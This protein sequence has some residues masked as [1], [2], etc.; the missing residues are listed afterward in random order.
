M[1]GQ[2]GATRQEGRQCVPGWNAHGKGRPHRARGVALAGVLT[3]AVA[4]AG[5][6]PADA[7][8]NLVRGKAWGANGSVKTIDPPGISVGIGRVALQQMPCRP[9]LGRAYLNQIDLSEFGGNANTLDLGT[10]VN[11]GIV[12]AP[13][14]GTRRLE[15]SSTIQEFS[16]LNGLVHGSAVKTVLVRD[17]SLSE[18]NSSK[19]TIASLTI[20]GRVIEVP[21]GGVAPGTLISLGGKSFVRLHER[22]LDDPGLRASAIHIHLE[23]FPTV[24]LGALTGDIYIANATIDRRQVDAL[25]R[26]YAFGLSA[27]TQDVVRVGEQAVVRLP[28]E[29]GEDEEVQ[30]AFAGP[31]QAT[32]LMSSATLHS[33]TLGTANIPDA[34]ATSRVQ[35]LYLFPTTNASDSAPDPIT[36]EETNHRLVVSGVYVRSRSTPGSDLRATWSFDLA[37]ISTGPTGVI[38]LPPNP[39]PNAFEISVPGVG[40]VSINRQFCNG[41]KFTDSNFAG[42]PESCPS[43]HDDGRETLD[44]SITGV[45]V[46]VLD[47]VSGFPP[48]TLI[49]IAEAA[50]GMTR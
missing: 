40:L 31:L 37:S 46:R 13:R 28:C 22:D 34:L 18:P 38:H 11:R 45:F 27:R 39:D 35:Q 16:A 9:K 5:A 3:L 33:L 15:E 4:G 30:L 7:A 43:R 26:G 50:T 41:R 21:A 19:V 2:G 47:P 23:E 12:T 6:T 44:H 25:L 36:G 48:G 10:V 49:K 14:P 29:G 42:W 24:Q 20:D 32:P 1:H 8:V 17:T